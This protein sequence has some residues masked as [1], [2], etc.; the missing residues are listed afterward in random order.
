MKEGRS[1]GRKEDKEEKSVLFTGN[2]CEKT[3]E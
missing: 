2:S 3:T 1:D